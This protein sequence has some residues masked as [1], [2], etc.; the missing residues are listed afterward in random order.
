MPEA[1]FKQYVRDGKREVKAYLLHWQ[2]PR[3]IFNEFKIVGVPFLA[4]KDEIVLTG[5]LDKVEIIRDGIVNVVDYKTGKPRTRNEIMG[6][7]KSSNGDYLRQLLFYKLLLNRYKQGEWK[8]EKGTIDF[9]KPDPRGKFHREEFEI[10]DEEVRELENSVS[11]AVQNILSLS[12][13]NQTCGEKEC[14]W[15]RLKDACKL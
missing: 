10:G 4:G 1:D 3:A 2:F 12:F 15:C 14:E 5:K 8:M 13:W 9:I 7:T 6:K 11:D